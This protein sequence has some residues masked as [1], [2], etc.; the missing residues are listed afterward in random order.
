MCCGIT[1]VRGK[2]VFRGPELSGQKATATGHKQADLGAH[3][4][5]TCG[6]N[7]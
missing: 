2:I 3:G 6:E 7:I 1:H 5:L 4:R